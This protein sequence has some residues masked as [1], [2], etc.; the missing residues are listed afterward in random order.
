MVRRPTQTDIAQKV[1]VSRGLVSL[2]LS[3]SPGVGEDTREKILTAAAELGYIRNLNAA[4]L[5]GQFRSTL[6]VVLPDLRNPFF[7]S[8]VAQLQVFGS[9]V[10][11]LPLLVTTQDDP[12]TERQVMRQL[13]EQQVAGVIFA[14]P[15][16]D[17]KD[18]QS[19]A[20]TLPISAI[21]VEPVG[22]F[23]DTTHI[24]EDVAARLVFDY[25]QDQQYER[26]LHL[27]IPAGAGDVWVE[28]RRIALVQAFA[29]CLVDHVTIEEGV[30]IS[31][32]LQKLLDG[33]KR[34]AIIAH[35]DLLAVDVV[36]AVRGMGL[37]PG[38]DV[39]I[40]SYDDTHMAQRPEFS[41]TS[42]HQDAGE[43]VKNAVQM[44]QSRRLDIDEAG[45]DLVVQP[46]LTIRQSA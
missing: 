11:L 15:V 46:T 2:A 40:V 10:G 28:R 44:I 45:R 21:G 30:S 1:G 35:N 41:L 5:A 20:R 6:G 23:V 39:G 13:L 17:A 36:S 3:G 25:L 27:S 9:E 43:L 22:G 42:V 19:Y 14:S 12:A 32:A 31:G 37:C 16:G 7:E 38:I 29:T 24:D 4:A 26:F 33:D 34:V 18:L 8:L